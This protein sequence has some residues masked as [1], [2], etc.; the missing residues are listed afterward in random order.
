MSNVKSATGVRVIHQ[1]LPPEQ[2]GGRSGFW[3]RL[4]TALLPGNRGVEGSNNHAGVGFK[5][6]DQ[7]PDAPPFVADPAS[8]AA[9]AEAL[10]PLPLA[11]SPTLTETAELGSDPPSATAAEPRSVAQPDATPVDVTAPNAETEVLPGQDGGRTPTDLW[12]VFV[13]DPLE[14]T[15]AVLDVARRQ[16]P[17]MLGVE[18]AATD[19][20][21]L[22]AP[23]RSV[24]IGAPS[25]IAV[26]L[27]SLVADLTGERNTLSLEVSNLRS[28]VSEL[29]GEVSRLVQIVGAIQSALP[30]LNG[31]DH[32]PLLP[33]GVEGEPATAQPQA[34]MPTTDA[35]DN[36]PT[37]A[38]DPVVPERRVPAITFT[39]DA[40]ANGFVW[41]SRSEGLRPFQFAERLPPEAEDLD[42]DEGATENLTASTSASSDFDAAP[43]EMFSGNTPSTRGADTRAEEECI[44]DRSETGESAAPD[45]LPFAVP[46]ELTASFDTNTAIFPANAALLT[47]I[48]G[49]FSGVKQVAAVEAG[50][51]SVRGVGPLQLVSYRGREAAFRFGLTLPTALASLTQAIAAAGGEVSACQVDDSGRALRISL[52]SASADANGSA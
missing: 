5:S 52:G 25:Q 37:T 46:A 44:D 1:D 47:L 11:V 27:R 23:R 2:R 32:A 15:R 12:P 22:P 20:S 19:N 33:A 8:I 39:V 18:A 35:I 51:A 14:R 13:V 49:P 48:A 17:G 10:R 42:S 21:S 30:G 24:G 43:A 6:Q 38:M 36:L 41:R 40:A 26:D 31:A 7:A 45:R 4:G 9:A 16:M 34:A 29:G 50:L 28:I 3:R